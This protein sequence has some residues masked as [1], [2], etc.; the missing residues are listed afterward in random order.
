MKNFIYALV[1]ALLTSCMAQKGEKEFTHRHRPS[2]VTDSPAPAVIMLHGYG[3]NSDDLFGLRSH[4]PA[5][6]H[7]YSLQAPVAMENGAYGWYKL[8]FGK[9]R[10]LRY[11][12]AEAEKARKFVV[13][14]INDVSSKQNVDKNR[15][16]LLGF[17]QGAI[18]SL[19]IAA[20]DPEVPWGVVA[21]SGGMM[22]ES[23][24]APGTDKLKDKRFFIGHCTSDEVVPFGLAA[25]AHTFLAS[26]GAKVHL[27]QYEGGHFIPAEEL[28]DIDSWLT[29][30]LLTKQ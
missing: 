7:V 24:K 22:T 11:D 30:M 26:K 4:I 19:D 1:A 3:S 25:E 20:V 8:D 18:L 14:F 28:Q 10:D 17:S 13:E 2:S 15:I 21:L 29:E 23:K 6:Y 16:I 12:Y 5:G 27:K 9:E